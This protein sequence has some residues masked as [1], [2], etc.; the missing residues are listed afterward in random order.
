MVISFFNKRILL[1][2]R[3]ASTLSE[4]NTRWKLE[5]RRGKSYVLRDVIFLIPRDCVKLNHVTGIC[6]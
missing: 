6:A 5:E 4:K 3:E 1:Q 2:I